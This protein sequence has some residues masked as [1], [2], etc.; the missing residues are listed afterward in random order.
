MI[1]RVAVLQC[2]IDEIS[3]IASVISVCGNQWFWVIHHGGTNMFVYGVKEAALSIG[4]LR[5][6]CV[7]QGLCVVGSLSYRLTLSSA[8]V[9]HSFTIPVLGVKCD[10]VPGRCNMICLSSSS[11]GSLFGQCSEICGS[12]HGYMPICIFCSL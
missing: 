3:S 1:V 10:V 12:F 7:V 11:S 9:I 8:D 6:I 5:V 2:G 4:D